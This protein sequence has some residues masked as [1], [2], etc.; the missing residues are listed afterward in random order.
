M[1]L[2]EQFTA[3][4]NDLKT[5]LTSKFPA[6]EDATKISMKALQDT[7]D[8]LTADI[9]ARDQ[10][11]KDLNAQVTKLTSDI[12]AKDGEI[13][14]LKADSKTAGEIA[15]DV[16]ASQGIEAGKAPA[17]GKPGAGATT[18]KSLQAQ[19]HELLAKDPKAAGE[20]YAENSS[21]TEFWKS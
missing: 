5:F 1:T 8:R 19:Y 21:K 20:F 17:A 13:T 6:A 16:V 10:T 11:I 7:S 14:K 3:A 4:I 2:S 12:A 15:T 9:A 18:A